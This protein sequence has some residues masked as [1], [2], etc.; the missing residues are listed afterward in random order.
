M[1]LLLQKLTYLG[2]FERRQIHRALRS[3][4]RHDCTREVSVAHQKEQKAVGD[5]K[6]DDDRRAGLS[7]DCFATTSHNNAPGCTKMLN[8]HTEP[9]GSSGRAYALVRLELPEIPAEYLLPHRCKNLR[10]DWLGAE[11]Q[12]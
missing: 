3:V 9:H 11:V 1:T 5:A 8:E 2:A 4:R 10:R 7:C 12:K 6:S